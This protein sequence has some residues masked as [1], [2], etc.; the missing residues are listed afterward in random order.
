M[1]RVLMATDGSSCALQA[2]KYVAKMFLNIPD[3]EIRVL[4]INEMSDLEEVKEQ[5]E[6]IKDTALKNTLEYFSSFGY[7]ATS[8]S[9]KGNA[10]EVICSIAEHENFDLVVVGSSGK[11]AIKRALLGSVS[12]KV[13]NQAGVPVLVVREKD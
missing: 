12:Y 1:F 11:G 4:Y 7:R 8:R 6:K 10:A 2:A 9:A 3:V 5:V 13:V